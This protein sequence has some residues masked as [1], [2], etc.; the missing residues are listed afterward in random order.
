MLQQHK[1]ADNGG[2]V[3]LDSDLKKGECYVSDP[4]CTETYDRMKQK[5][6]TSGILGEKD[7]GTKPAE[8][9]RNPKAISQMRAA[10]NNSWL[11]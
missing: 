5:V 1:I 9:S 8:K 2:D 6:T 11:T 10:V 4:V 3:V 7:G